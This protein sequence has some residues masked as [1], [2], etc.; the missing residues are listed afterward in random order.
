MSLDCASLTRLRESDFYRPIVE[1]RELGEELTFGN[2]RI[3]FVDQ[4]HGG[5]TSLGITLR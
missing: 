3:R 5:P 2:A 1:P 4:P